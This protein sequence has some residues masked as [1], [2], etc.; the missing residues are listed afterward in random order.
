MQCY[1]ELTPPTAVTHSLSLPFLSATANNLVVAKSSL[2]QIFSLKSVITHSQDGVNAQDTAKTRNSMTNGTTSHPDST[3]GDRLQSTKLVLIAQ[4][5]LSGTVTSLAR[6]KV[7]QSR[8]GG[9][10]LLVALRD[11]KLSLVEWDP[12]RYSVSTISIHYYEREDILSSPW[13]PDLGQCQNYLC[14]DP[15]SRCAA[16]KFGKRH[17]AILPF[18]QIGDDLIMDD[19]DP[20]MDGERP[21]KKPSTSKITPDDAT[22]GESPYDASFVLS[23]MALDPSLSHPIQL[24]FLYEYRDPTFGVLYS[25]VASSIAMLHERR[26]NVSYAVYTLDLEQRASTTLLSV[27]NL[28][29]DLFAVISLSR[30]IGGALLVGGNEIIHVDQSGKA[31]GVAVNEFAKQSTTFAMADQTDLNMRLEHSIIQQLGQDNAELLIILKTGTLAIL[32]FRIDGRSVSGLQIRKVTTENGGATILA[33]PSCASIVGRGRIFIGSEDSDSVVLGWSRKADRLKRKRSRSNMITDD[34]KDELGM[35]E[36]EIEDDEDDLYTDSK[37]EEKVQERAI[38]ANADLDEDYRFRVHDA[39]LNIG[40]MTD[41]VLR[42]SSK[43][44]DS[45]RESKP[46][47]DLLTASGRGRCGGLTILQPEIRLSVVEQIN[48]DKVRGIWSVRST[49][50]QDKASQMGSQEPYDKYIFTSSLTEGGEVKPAA[51]II[52]SGGLEEIRDAEFDP[53][54]GDI[55]EIGTINA[56][57]RIV[58]VLQSEARSYDEGE[59]AFLSAYKP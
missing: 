4:Y 43:D 47:T 18:H 22:A 35:D 51:Y 57:S 8:S 6:V 42:D 2:L 44:I 3:R 55:V 17:L 23:L 20:D 40:P 19:Y 48:V 52:K 58:Q 41:I 10:A 32:S 36:D 59:S 38:S 39:M 29:Y 26:D 21:E 9:E 54:A 49:Q 30:P 1:T 15:S 11:A 27:N 33:G 56:G 16:F 50:S 7:L 31:N 5:E 28:P 46:T 45:S 25:Q 13:D 53:D 14:V 37:P 12:E 24:S 34:D